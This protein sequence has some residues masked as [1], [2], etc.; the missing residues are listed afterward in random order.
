MHVSLIGVF[1][2]HLIPS[3]SSSSFAFDFS[4]FFPYFLPLDYVHLLSSPVFLVMFAAVLFSKDTIDRHFFR[5]VW[6]G[7][8][9]PGIGFFPTLDGF[10]L[11]FIT[12]ST[13][14]S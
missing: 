8:L 11:V 12:S 3:S 13:L 2:V 7:V 1:C 4:F 14:D 9:G 5:M 6:L 10:L